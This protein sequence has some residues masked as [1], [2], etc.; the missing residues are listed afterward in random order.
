MSRLLGLSKT[1]RTSVFVIGTKRHRDCYTMGKCSPYK[2]NMR[3][4]TKKL[5]Q[6]SDYMI[7]QLYF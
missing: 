3:G 2:N 1:Q 7:F 5:K 6:Q 4:V